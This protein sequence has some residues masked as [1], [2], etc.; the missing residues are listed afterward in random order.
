MSVR[1]GDRYFGTTT[2]TPDATPAAAP[3][4]AGTLGERGLKY[5]LAHYSVNAWRTLAPE[6]H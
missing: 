3:S 4:P 6:V 1:T 2:A 5:I